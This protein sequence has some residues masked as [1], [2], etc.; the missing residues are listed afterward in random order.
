MGKKIKLVDAYQMHRRNA[1]TFEVPTDKDLDSIRVGD[2]VKLG[3]VT[4]NQLVSA[5]RMWVE[6][7]GLNPFKGRLVSGPLFADVKYHDLVDFERNHVH[8]IKLKKE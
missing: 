8:S 5:E 2:L 3:F 4:G 6:V 7:V 1:T